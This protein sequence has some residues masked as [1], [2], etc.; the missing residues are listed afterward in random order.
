MAKNLEALWVPLEA[1]D[2]KLADV[3]D[4]IDR[5]PR[6]FIESSDK[7]Q[8]WLFKN[9][10]QVIF[11]DNTQTKIWDTTGSGSITLPEKITATIIYGAFKQSH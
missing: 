4:V 8:G 1:N 9:C 7:E 6:G 3:D 5:T 10:K 2:D 11:F